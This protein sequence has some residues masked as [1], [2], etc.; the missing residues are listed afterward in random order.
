MNVL[1]T[2]LKTIYPDKNIFLHYVTSPLIG[3]EIR[4]TLEVGGILFADLSD[5]KELDNFVNDLWNKKMSRLRNDK[6]DMTKIS[7]G[8]LHVKDITG[9]END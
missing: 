3:G 6:F 9:D 5:A 8:P 2:K 1:L 4:C 7:D